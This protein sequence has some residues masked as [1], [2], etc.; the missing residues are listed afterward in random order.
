MALT[1]PCSRLV[2]ESF[3]VV[4]MAEQTEPVRRK[5]A[6]KII[7]PGM[8]TKEVVVRFEAERQALALTDH[9]NIA[10]VFDGGAKRACLQLGNLSSRHPTVD[11]EP[12]VNTKIVPKTRRT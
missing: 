8:D 6:L 9:P 12:Q 10:K 3:G 4:D 11:I 1:S 2:R 7:K 5:V